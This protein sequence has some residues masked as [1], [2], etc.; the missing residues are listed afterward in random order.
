MAARYTVET[1]GDIALSAATA[2]TIMNVINAT[3]GLI[4]IVEIGVSFDGTSATAEP[5]TVELCNSTQ[6]TAGTSTAH[7]ILQ[8]GGPTRTVQ[9]TAARNYTAEPTT[10]TVLKRWLVHPAG[11]GIIV[12]FPLGREPEQVT[13]ADGL[14]IRCTAPAT[15][16]VQ[17]YMEFEEG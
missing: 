14:C 12:Q 4:R 16:N 17:G 8:T 11:G 5:V 7:T 1:N 10:L 15:V 6:A 3:N 13:T 2:K 9:A